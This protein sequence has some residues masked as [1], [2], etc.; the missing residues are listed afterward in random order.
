MLSYRPYIQPAM[1]QSPGTFRWVLNSSITVGIL[2]L[3]ALAAT[4]FYLFQAVRLNTLTVDAETFLQLEQNRQ[5]ATTHLLASLSLDGQDL[6]YDSTDHTYYCSLTDSQ[7]QVFDPLVSF[8]PARNAVRMVFLDDTLTAQRLRDGRPLTILVYSDTAF[9]LVHVALTTLPLAQVTL[10]QVPSDANLPI[11]EN[12]VTGHLTLYDNRTGVSGANRVFS[13]DL[14]IHERGSTSKDYP[15]NSYKLHLKTNNDLPR[16]VK[17]PLLGMRQSDDWIL[18]A[19]YNDPDRVRNAM[20]N[21]LWYDMGAQSN[22]QDLTIG[23]RARMVELF[24]G[25]RY[26]GVYTLME[27]LDSKTAA[28]QG[29]PDPLRSEYLYRS[30]QVGDFDPNIF[31]KV[32]KGQVAGNYKLCWPDDEMVTA[33]KWQRLDDFLEL[34]HSDDQTFL[35]S[36]ANAVDLDNAIDMWLFLQVTDAADNDG[37]NMFYISKGDQDQTTMLFAPWDLDQT[38]GN[39]WTNILPLRTGIRPEQ[40]TTNAPPVTT[41]LTR[42]ILLEQDSTLVNRIRQRYGQ[43]RQGVLSDQALRERVEEYDQ[44]VYASGAQVREGKRWPDTTTNGDISQL[45]GFVLQRM[46]VMDGIIAAMPNKYR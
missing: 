25:D 13:S 11:G 17:M 43:L 10:D 6:L 26:W 42:L 30:L 1:E 27:P 36:Y 41:G 33:L 5:P 14:T 9:E 22:S 37:K 8:A 38:W 23:V 46:Q 28:L 45:T 18:Y 4:Q 29:N 2:S 44:A 16:K 15:K 32:E 21:N 19:G 39:A 3:I 12:T 7:V 40:I 24:I 35:R 34:L 31:S 20:A